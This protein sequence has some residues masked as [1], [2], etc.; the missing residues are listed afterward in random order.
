MRKIKG[1]NILGIILALLLVFV[2]AGVHAARDLQ[3]LSRDSEALAELEL[4]YVNLTLNEAMNDI[5]QTVFD[6][7]IPVRQLVDIDR[8]RGV[9]NLAK[10]ILSDNPAMCGCGLVF[11]P[12]YVETH[13]GCEDIGLFRDGDKI[14]DIPTI[15]EEFVGTEWYD[16]PLRERRD[17]WTDPYVSRVY[18]FSVCTFAHP[19]FN[20]EDQLAGVFLVDIPTDWLKH[21]INERRIYGN[22]KFL[23]LNVSGKVVL[24]SDDSFEIPD[25][26]HNFVY[27]GA[28]GNRGSEMILSVPYSIVYADVINDGIFTAFIGL[29]IVILMLIVLFGTLRGERSRQQAETET[30]LMEKEMNIAHDIQMGMVPARFPD[31]PDVK[32]FA[33]M[34]PA[35]EIGGDFYD[36]FI[37]DEKLFFCIGDVSGKGVPASLLMAMS[38]IMFRTL[39]DRESNPRVIV[40]SMHSRIRELGGRNMFV[41]F[42]AGVLDLPTGTLRYC[43]AG[44]NPPAIV[45]DGRCGFLEVKPNTPLGFLREYSFTLEDTSISAGR[46]LFL[47]TDGVTEAMDRSQALFGEGRMKAALE[48]CGSTD[49]EVLTEKTCEAVGSFTAGAPQSDDLTILAIRYTPQKETILLEKTIVLENNRK[50][51]ARLGEFIEEF[52]AEAGIGHKEQLDINLAVEEVATNCVLYSYPEGAKG[53]VEIT[54]RK[55]PERYIFIIKDTGKPFDPTAA[56]EADL[57]RNSQERRKGGLGIFLVRKVMDTINYEYSGRDNILTL[58]KNYSATV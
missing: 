56:P 8:T 11:Y 50:E 16:I 35:K 54:A 58:T 22:A 18:G 39:G 52:A 4:G 19:I 12:S 31:R 20:G 51:I 5:R 30:R 40:S 44:H 47:Y 23:L 45:E 38:R 25:E 14:R 9:V 37:R 26:R 43:N 48:A 27:R 41:T 49:P 34:V 57:K 21:K 29:M 13:P 2:V 7:S 17:V 15:K 6:L 3:R 32:I 10:G 33:K 42:F 46:T 55:T 24:S 28:I 36:F 1:Y 53:T